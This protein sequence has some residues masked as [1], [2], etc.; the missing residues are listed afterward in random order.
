M[1]KHDAKENP[2][3][4]PSLSDTTL[5]DRDARKGYPLTGER[6]FRVQE[7]GIA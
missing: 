7:E 3:S 1:T 6:S 4:Y 5:H 2:L